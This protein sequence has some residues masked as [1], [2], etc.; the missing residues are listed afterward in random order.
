MP[1]GAEQDDML[2]LYNELAPRGRQESDNFTCRFAF[3]KTDAPN[4]S[5]PTQDLFG[6]DYFGNGI[7][8]PL[9]QNIRFQAF[10][11]ID[12]SV[13]VEFDDQIDWNQAG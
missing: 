6:A 7:V 10:D 9:C 1:S 13:I 4:L 2:M 12:R 5:A 3:D 11:Q 8:S